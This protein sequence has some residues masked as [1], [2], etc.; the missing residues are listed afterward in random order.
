MTPDETRLWVWY[1]G[2]AGR[3]YQLGV[4]DCF[5]LLLDGQAAIDLGRAFEPAYRKGGDPERTFL[6]NFTRG[7]AA[8]EKTETAVPGAAVL[9]RLGR[10][11][12]HVGLVMGQGLM[13]HANTTT[14]TTLAQYGP[15]T[16]YH[17]L[18]A[19]FYVPKTVS[20]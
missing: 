3:A 1:N 19:G 4:W 5:Q 15:G 14:A 13:A 12:I 10:V 17:T 2:V 20:L 9:F 18:F 7:F 16:D 6:R 11:P 8:F